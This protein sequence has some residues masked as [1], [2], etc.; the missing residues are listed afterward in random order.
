MV[1]AIVEPYQAGRFDNYETT[2]V[3]T[4]CEDHEIETS[5]DRH[6]FLKETTTRIH[7]PRLVTELLKNTRALG[8]YTGLILVMRSPYEAYL[9]QVEASSTKWLESLMPDVSEETFTQFARGSIGALA[10]IAWHARAQHHRIVSYRQFCENPA[11]EL[12]RL[13]G[14]FPLRLETPQL[15]LGK[16]RHRGGDAKAYSSE[17]I[18]FSD[19]S[20]EIENLKQ[21]VSKS[22]FSNS[23]ERLHQLYE[24]MPRL[25]D[26]TVLDRLTEITI[27]RR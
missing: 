20:T 14:L 12:A 10:H 15:Q 26:D 1:D 6:L 21:I 8:V 17:R 16:T 25:A 13:M 23:M 18:E 24:E 22:P 19:R 2:S 9:S 11:N 27:M 7:N 5:E 3:S 4:L